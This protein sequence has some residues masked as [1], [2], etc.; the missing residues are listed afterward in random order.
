MANLNLTRVV[1][2]CLAGLLASGCASTARIA[3]GNKNLPSDNTVLPG[4]PFYP[5]RAVCRQETV[6]LEPIYVLTREDS[7]TTSDPKQ[8]RIVKEVKSARRSDLSNAN[9]DMA[10][11]VALQAALNR[12]KGS[13]TE[14]A[15]KNIDMAWTA[16]AVTPT[17]SLAPP[18]DTDLVLAADSLV[19]DFYVDYSRPYYFNTRMPWLGSSTAN[20]TL[21]P[22]GT[23][24]QGQATVDNQTVSAI[25][26][27]LPVNA[28][29]SARLG[30][31]PAAGA[32]SPAA[33]SNDFTIHAMREF[34]T[35]DPAPSRLPESIAVNVETTYV[36]HVLSHSR[37]QQNSPCSYAADSAP[38]KLSDRGTRHYQYRMESVLAPA[39]PSEKAAEKAPAD[40]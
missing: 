2:L 1:V 9:G 38:L 5:K 34:D 30:L 17:M 7:F 33:S 32:A 37:E 22:D 21:A 31:T 26:S 24:T 8:P 4:I 10:K 25:L 11:I 36:K 19:P 23:L 16:L 35:D 6:W 27:L 20:A 39:K 13:M 28:L 15:L 12:A 29:L 3:T 40:Q 14:A 18:S